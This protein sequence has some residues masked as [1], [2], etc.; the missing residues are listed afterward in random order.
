M[1]GAE[2]LPVDVTQVHFLCDDLETVGVD[3]DQ[4]VDIGVD[5]CGHVQVVE[6]RPVIRVELDVETVGLQLR[7][8]HTS[9][10][11]SRIQTSLSEGLSKEKHK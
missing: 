10:Q 2:L 5:G 7:V 4:G 11:R 3:I 9:D 6:Q 8:L 1:H